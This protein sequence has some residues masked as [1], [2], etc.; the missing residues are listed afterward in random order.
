MQLEGIRIV[1]LS[2]ILSGPFCSMFLA[3]MGAEVIKIE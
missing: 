2:R 3:D 1:D